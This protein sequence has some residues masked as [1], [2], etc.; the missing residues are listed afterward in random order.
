MCIKIKLQN[1]VNCTNSTKASSSGF[2]IQIKTI[3]EKDD[4]ERTSFILNLKKNKKKTAELTVSC[5]KQKVMRAETEKKNVGSERE[6]E[7]RKST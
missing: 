7:R 2:H 3:N 4:L 6:T 5:V 1:I